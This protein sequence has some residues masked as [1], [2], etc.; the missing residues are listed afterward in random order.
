MRRAGRWCTLVLFTVACSDTQGVSPDGI[1]G[2]ELAAVRSAL[3]CAAQTDP[4]F[5]PIG[6]FV[7]PYIDRATRL[8]SPGGDTTS[9][10]GIELDVH[11]V[12]DS[13]PVQVGLV[14]VLAWTGFDSLTQTVDTTVLLLGSSGELPIEDSLARGFSP[15]VPGEGSGVVVHSPTP[16]TCELWAP[17]TGLLRVTT[18]SFGA[19][20]TL[21]ADTLSLTLFRGT[22]GGD[23]A[24][25]AKLVPDSIT[26]V[27]T[28][29][30]YGN[31]AHALKM[32]ITG[33]ALP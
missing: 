17:R 2:E 26:T 3:V 27:S 7:L 30:A 21:G 18:A 22:V 32:R 9:V 20:T 16:Q 8:V 29:Q 11:A 6:L 15:A 19:G 12:V 5:A 23:Y 33:F 13:M 4:L 1:P 31:G 25:T 14:G 10:S 24:V 28:A